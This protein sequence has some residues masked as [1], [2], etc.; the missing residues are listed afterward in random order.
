MAELLQPVDDRVASTIIYTDGSCLG[1]PGPGGWAWAIQGG[2][3][4]SGAERLTTNQRMEVTAALEALEW[5]T[6]NT[7]GHEAKA[8]VVSDSSYLVNC[9]NFKW[10]EGWLKRQWRNSKGHLVAN[11]DLWEP[12]LELVLDG[13]IT[14]EFSWTKGHAGNDMNE[15]VDSMANEAA[16]LQRGV[17][18][19]GEDVR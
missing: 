9:F 17:W 16:R 4:A 19:S 18:I 5:L 13:P 10:W 11:R 8:V 14:V 6:K 7:D 1:N 15:L 12:L 2:P 3:S